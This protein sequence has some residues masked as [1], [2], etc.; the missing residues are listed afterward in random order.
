MSSSSEG[1]HT[2]VRIATLF[3]GRWHVPKSMRYV[4]AV[5]TYDYSR[6]I[7]WYVS[8]SACQ[9]P[10]LLVTIDETK[11]LQEADAL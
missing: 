3:L 11:T 8:R 4:L 2:Q 9:S 7:R 6:I 5:M 1:N 10:A